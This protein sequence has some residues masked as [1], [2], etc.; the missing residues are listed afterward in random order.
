[1]RSACASTGSNCV[2]RVSLYTEVSKK[3]EEPCPS[4]FGKEMSDQHAL[5]YIEEMLREQD[6]RLAFQKGESS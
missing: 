6:R 2:C 1:M 5:A 4:I 3:K